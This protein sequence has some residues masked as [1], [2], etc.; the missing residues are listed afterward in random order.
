[1]AIADKNVVGDLFWANM[2]AEQVY[3]AFEK[4]VKAV[5]ELQRLIVWAFSLFTVGGAIIGFFA[6]PEQ[7]SSVTLVVLGTGFAI[8]VLAYYLTTTA[9]FPVPM[10]LRPN[11]PEIIR[12]AFT[13]AIMK[14]TTRFQKASTVTFIGFLFI[15]VGI[16]IQF[17]EPSEKEKPAENTEL[18]FNT[19]IEN[20][21]TVIFIPVTVHYKEKTTIDI[22]VAP[23]D[24]P[25][26][27]AD[28]IYKDKKLFYQIF[29][30]DSFGNVYTSCQLPTS[31]IKAFKVT[32]TSREKL[33][34]GTLKEITITKDLKL[35]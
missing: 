35:N 16:L 20:R 1:M 31:K 12:A 33:S 17:S 11:E 3:N 2:A 29:L 5:T 13:E 9:A 25:L 4:R 15:A 23:N 6:K 10:E 34:D 32:V 30:T 21:S 26:T 19:K 24:N 27:G 18:S 7:Y 28:S 8:L 22:S 14:N